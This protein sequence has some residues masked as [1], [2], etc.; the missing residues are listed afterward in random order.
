M[1]KLH[2]G[3]WLIIAQLGGI[4]SSA[5]AQITSDTTLLNNSAA[6]RNG[7]LVTIDEG[8]VN[9]SNLFHSFSE[10]NVRTGETAFFNNGLTIDNIITRVTG[11]EL[12][13]INGLI[14][15]NGAAN[16]FLLNPSGI[17]FGPNARLDIG[18]SFVGST[19][20]SFLF[21]DGSIY[22]ATN[23][24]EAPLLT[25]NVPLGLQYGSNPN[26][27]QVQEANLEVESGQTLTLA[28]GDLE[29]VGGQL[30]VSDGR[31]SLATVTAGNLTLDK[32][33]GIA[34]LYDTT[35]R[36]NINLSQQSL[37]E[38]TGV[39]DGID[40]TTGNF[41]LTE[42]SRLQSVA[43]VPGKAG[44]ITLNATDTITID[45]FSTDGLFSG[46]LSH[47]VEENG[48]I[49]GNIAINQ[50]NN[51]Q[52][53][54]TLSNRG[55]IATVTENN[56]YSG[57]IEVNVN[58]LDLLSGGQIISLTT[59]NG[60]SGNITVNATEEIFIS[61]SNSEFE[62]SPF[63]DF[64]V[65]DLNQL[66]FTT[67]AD[68]N[69]EK[70]ETIPHVS[71]ERTPKKIK[72][73]ATILGTAED[74]VFDIYSF[75][76]TEADSQGVFDIDFG[77]ENSNAEDNLDAEGNID[78]EIFLF[79][80]KTGELLKSNNNKKV[81]NGAAG[82]DRKQDSY[83]ATTFSEPG[84]FVIAVGEFNTHSSAFPVLTT[85]N[86]V[87][88]DTP[89]PILAGN[90]VDRGDT[91]TLQVSV[92]NQ[93]N[94]I[95]NSPTLN[96]DNFNPNQRV[97]SGIFSVSKVAGN[98]GNI[99]IKTGTLTV[100]DNGT[101]NTTPL[102]T[103]QGGNLN[104]DVTG[105]V[106]LNDGLLSTI[107]PSNG[108][109]GDIIINADN[110][111]LIDSEISA[112]TLVE[113]NAGDINIIVSETIDARKKSIIDSQTIGSGN[114]GNIN[115]AAGESIFLNGEE[116]NTLYVLARTRGQGNAGS[117]NLAAGESISL[118]ETTVDSRTEGE[119][120]AGS[121]NLTAG[122]SISLNETRV[123]SRTEGEGNAGSVNL[124][125]GE[126]ISLNKTRLWSRTEGKGNAGS[127]NLTAD[128][129]ISLDKTTVHSRTKG[130]GNAGPINVK[131]KALTLIASQFSASSREPGSGNAGFINL[132]TEAIEIS[133]RLSEGSRAGLFVSVID[134]AI[135]KG[136]NIIVDTDR[137][138]I[139]DGGT[140]NASNFQS[141]DR[142]ST[143][144]GPVGNIEINANS[145]L[146][147]NDAVITAAAVTG[148]KG[149]ITINATD[150]HLEGGSDGPSS[151]TV[152]AEGDATGGHL[153]LN[154]DKLSLNDSSILAKT[155]GN[156]N[157]GSIKINAGDVSFTNNS[158]LGV[159]SQGSGQGGSIFFSADNLT[160]D[161][162]SLITAGTVSNQGGDINLTLNDK[163][164][165][166][167]NSNISS[168]AGTA[169]AGGDGGNLIISAPFIIA[170]PFEDSDITA[171]AFEGKGGNINITANGIF[172]LAFRS[173]PTPRSDITASSKFGLAG[174]V[175][176][177][178]PDV[179]PTS[180]L[181]EL[182]SQVT[183]PSN[184]VIAGC[185]A[186]SGNSFTVTGKGGLPENP[187][188]TTIYGQTILSDLRDFTASDKKE[189]LSP[190]KK[191]ARQQP[192]R[193]IVQVNG[194]IVNQD[195][196]VELVAAL[197]Q[198]TSFLK[199]PNCQDLESLL[200]LRYKDKN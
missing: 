6:T 85:G 30:Q 152:R 151:I 163:L 34:G 45:G 173:E 41:S 73:G 178:N 102:G 92:E 10:F 150:I 29:I 61:G 33:L 191:Q 64:T 188:N 109:A 69:I 148:D 89:F 75:G 116:D 149:N 87:D 130:E 176:I 199:H 78:T 187:I 146:L 62:P 108:D 58:N 37:V 67:E 79:N 44:D 53:N 81:K 49:G 138:I 182:P 167:N 60:D 3:F 177:N 128:E 84:T 190:V 100:E 25:V 83:L 156:G 80:L 111:S 195:G 175:T 154:T 7:D 31:I 132:E 24:S 17:Q 104:F 174:N 27:I 97:N 63:E 93:G 117:V 169:G 113:G 194:W 38:V 26:P 14:Q 55:F 121:V 181:A 133:G 144:L 166:R 88:S 160:L 131:T 35:N 12:S 200:L 180:A 112:S 28:G 164:L 59:G 46:I 86:T 185:A 107:T 114:A 161:K 8:T 18:G 39:S 16:L 126:S 162:N 106:H 124:A 123:Y 71:L 172:G 147:T 19:A 94:F 168:T 91:Y 184:K 51:P 48:G 139:R 47:S 101:I 155:L 122:E 157:A 143:G 171:N 21:E 32:S 77:R 72:S 134:E 158:T 96:P 165:L 23:P 2:F 57:D 197:P 65:F 119:G 136:G 179:D 103:G 159:N 43:E 198:E 56:S 125:A 142:T 54:L 196:E 22:S 74:G 66:T 141:D 129:S 192:P 11:G 99:T 137:L 76:V 153:T 36:G 127:V 183:D 20:E 52:G 186:A 82:S 90:T 40:I 105:T 1:N 70:S 135:G 9:G 42:G 115:L 98:S 140:I 4:G 15:A 189:D 170:P 118:N 13:T 120:N 50:T 5:L 68:P 193:S 95:D 145:I 110:I